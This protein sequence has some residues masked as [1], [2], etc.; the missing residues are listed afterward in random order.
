ME[1]SNL[2]EWVAD[3]QFPIAFLI[4][5]LPSLL[6][7]VVGILLVRAIYPDEER[8]ESRVVGAKINYMAETYAVVLGLFLVG[9]FN[10][11]QSMQTVVKTEA[12]SLR[13]LHEIAAQL[14]PS[15]AGELQERVRAYTRT[16][17]G[18]EWPL[19]KFGEESAAAQRELDRV[20]GLIAA[21]GKTADGAPGVSLQAQQAAQTILAQRA[22]RLSNGPGD[23][24]TLSGTFSYFLVVLTLVAIALPWFLYTP[25][26]LMH[27]VTAGALIVVFLTIIVLAVKMLY[28]FAGELAILSTDFQAA[29]LA[30]LE[31]TAETAAGGGL[32]P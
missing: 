32:P 5:A 27:I 30:M 13:A 31:R 8:I 7:S 12:M 24:D 4:I 14:P 15:A 28:P 2:L 26:P 16:V 17:I 21:V 22:T 1:P 23:G 10:D 18:E 6:V 19:M 20:F 25:H 9:A 11:Y 29:L 3:T